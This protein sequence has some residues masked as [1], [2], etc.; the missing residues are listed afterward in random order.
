MRNECLA[1]ALDE[2]HEAGIHD[3]SHAN[4][5]KHYQ[6]RWGANGAT[7]AYTLPN[8]PSDHRSA[9][10]CRADIRR[11]LREDGM[12]IDRPPPPPKPLDRV[13]RLEQR[14]AA[15]ELEVAALRATNETLK[16][17]I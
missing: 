12:L 16:E 8:T 13:S 17:Y 4:G 5:G 11:M 15:L 14:I 1:V 6:I 10:N 3:I 7:R 2:L 9:A